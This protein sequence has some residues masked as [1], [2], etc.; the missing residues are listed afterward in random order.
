MTLAG[1]R[2]RVAAM[3]ALAVLFAACKDGG[4]ETPRPTAVVAASPTTQTALT[5]TAVAQAPSVR[6][7]DQ[8]GQPLPNV[9]V[10]FVV[11][12]GG[13]SLAGG[14]ATTNAQ[15][16]ATAGAWTLGNVAG[17][18]SVTAT[19]GTLAPVQFIATAQARTPSTITAVS[20]TSQT[21]SAGA[22]VATPPSVRV[23]DQTGQPLP[24]VTVN[25]AVTSGG[26][27][28]GTASATTN[29]AGVAS[30]GSWTLG[31]TAG[32]NT[33]T[34]TVAGLAPVVFTATSTPS[35][36]PC[37]VAT[38]YTPLTTVSGQFTTADCRLNSGEYIDFYDVTLPSAQAISFR[39]GSSAVDTWL[40]LYNA[41][42]DILAV[43][44]DVS[45]GDTNSQIN[46]FAPSGDYFLVASTFEAGELGSYTLSSSAF[47]QATNCGEYWLVPGITLNGSIATN[48]C[49]SSGFYSD[50]Y[51]LVLQAG[52]QLTVRLESTAFDAML[53]LYD[54]VTGEIV[55]EDD[56]GAGGN[57][58]QIVYTATELS[59]FAINATTFSAGNTGAY[60][61]TV[62]TPAAERTATVRRGQVSPGLMDAVNAAARD[63]VGDRKASSSV[64]GSVLRA[65]SATPR[66]KRRG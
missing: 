21:G 6:V 61:M 8:K 51:F 36:D 23:N 14:T 26:G 62:T 33:L 41:D 44:D 12:G 47:T 59:I 66:I 63:R 13:G 15:G 32:Q 24:G 55:A 9:A 42:G 34:A 49:V 28:V 11:T 1:Q 50:L 16:V 22:P 10:T 57:N 38:L 37:T 17:Q 48:D 56:D 7:T 65:P 25:F 45:D 39:M 30:S 2:W 64:H 58:A 53:E 19:V 31:P 18:N 29:A 5:G 46:L 43:N 40:E 35:V 20:A 54:A 60:S 4:T 52:Q 27:T 3:G